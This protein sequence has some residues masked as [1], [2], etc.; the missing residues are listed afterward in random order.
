MARTRVGGQIMNAGIASR[1]LRP[2]TAS[3]G[4]RQQ[5]AARSDGMVSKRIA[6]IVTLI[7]C[8]SLFIVFA[9]SQLMHWHI[10]S[11]VNK[12][13]ELQSV[14][15]EYGSENVALLA[16]RA[17]LTSKEYVVEKAGRK[18]QLFVPQKNQVQRL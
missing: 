15:H 10:I 9:F 1:M 16:A 12:L 3:I 4:V 13:D 8:V 7:I 17:Q 5:V 6:R 14:R 18:Y 2:Q 11:T